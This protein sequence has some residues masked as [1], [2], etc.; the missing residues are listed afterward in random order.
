M[1]FIQMSVTIGTG[2]NLSPFH[3]ECLRFFLVKKKSGVIEEI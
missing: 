3:V 2:N 1:N